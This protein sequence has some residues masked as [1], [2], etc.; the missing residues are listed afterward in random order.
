MAGWADS[1]IFIYIFILLVGVLV[2][3]GSQLVS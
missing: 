2:G 1:S 3:V